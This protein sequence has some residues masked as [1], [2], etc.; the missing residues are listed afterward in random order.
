MSSRHGKNR[1]TTVSSRSLAVQ[2][3]TS[4][5]SVEGSSSAHYAHLSLRP[6]T[7][8]I[9]TTTTTT[10]SVHFAPLRIPR[11]P[12][13][14]LLPEAE[15]NQYAP[16]QSQASALDRRL[17]PKL[18]P[19]AAT[20]IPQCKFSFSMALD[21]AEA[22]HLLQPESVE[23]AAQDE[24]P[25]KAPPTPQST[26]KVEQRRDLLPSPRTGRKRSASDRGSRTLSSSID[27]TG[28]DLLL[29][30]RACGIAE[31]PRKKQKPNPPSR[32][33]EAPP[34]PQLSGEED[35]GP[36]CSLST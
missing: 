19:L 4:F 30:D 18:Y 15:R 35:V 28:Q 7:K 25:R 31:P 23:D 22:D 2:G 6:A 1:E 16:Y 17:D 12:D 5:G 21:Q 8:Q 26:I 29:S 10:T 14:T 3:D 27:E 9:T 11:V 32:S 34:S 24:E 13:P 20:E 33:A 36:V